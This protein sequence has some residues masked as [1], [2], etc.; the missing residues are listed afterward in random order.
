MMDTSDVATIHFSTNCIKYGGLNIYTRTGK[1][2]DDIVN[3]EYAY[4]LLNN[5]LKKVGLDINDLIMVD[6]SCIE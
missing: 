6:N 3:N 4:G 2:T 1:I 5:G